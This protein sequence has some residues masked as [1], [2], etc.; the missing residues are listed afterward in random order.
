MQYGAFLPH[1]GPLAQGDVL[2]RLKTTAQTAEAL[3]FDSVWVADHIITPKQIAS[4]YPY[5]PNGSFPLDPQAPL[6]EPLSVLSFVAACTHKVRLGTAVLVLPHR[7][8]IV[9]AKTLATLDVLSAGRL[10]CGVGVGWMEEEF[11]ILNAPF[12]D[13]GPLSEETIAVMKE[14]WTNENPSFTGRFYQ[15][16]EVG[17]EPRPV[18]KP[19][20]PIWIGGHTGP[21]LRR[22]VEHGDGWPAVV[23]SPQ[24][25]A[26]RVDKLK[27]KA[28]KAGR[29]LSEITLCVS[30]RGKKPDEILDDIPRYQEL[31]ASYLYLAFFNF[32][33]TYAD[34]MKMMEKFARDVGVA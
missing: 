17:C 7:N 28:A 1:L 18:Q 11:N 25:F 24:E 5:S 32:A 13:R 22:V 12:A 10:I 21:A 2:N 3:G 20:P 9:T 8:A 27:E 16:S 33:R 19:H 4:R 31:G 30:P 26:Q 29:D 15:F 6:L 14:L 34:M 23:F